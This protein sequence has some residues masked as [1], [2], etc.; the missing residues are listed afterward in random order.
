L[1]GEASIGS[2]SRLGVEYP[3]DHSSAYS[4][5]TQETCRAA[6]IQNSP[7]QVRFAGLFLKMDAVL[8]T[9]FPHNRTEK[10]VVATSQSP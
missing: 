2:L 6:E 3:S 8:A 9:R 4:R 7:L 5:C 1:V 10:V